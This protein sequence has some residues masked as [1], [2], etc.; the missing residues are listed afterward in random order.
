MRVPG[1]WHTKAEPRLCRIIELNE[2]IEISLEQAEAA[3]E[4]KEPPKS[5]AGDSSGTDKKFK[6][7]VP[8]NTEYGIA[9]LESEISELSQATEGSR[10]RCLNKA[11][12]CLGQLVAGGELAEGNVSSSLVATAILIG[13]LEAEA[14]ST[15][16]SGIQAGMVQPRSAPQDNGTTREQTQKSSDNS[17][18]PKLRTGAEIRNMEIKIEWLIDGIIPKNGVTLLFGRGG[19]GKTTLTL[20]MCQAISSGDNFLGRTTEKT[21]VI[22]IDFENSLSVLSERLRT[23]GADQV[24]FWSSSDSPRRLDQDLSI[25]FNLL[26]KYPG[27]VF[28]FDTLRSAQDGDEND[29][30]F[31][32]S[33]M[34]PLR[35]LRDLG[36]TVI[37]LHHTKKSSDDVYKGS[38][39]IFDLVDHVVGLYP[40]KKAGENK[41]SEGELA[42]IPIYF[43]GTKNKTRYRTFEQYLCFDKELCLFVRV[44]DLKEMML[45]K[46]R[47]KIPEIG[48]IQ[49]NLLPILKTSLGI[50]E[51]KALGLLKEGINRYWSAEKDSKSNNAVTYK[52]FPGFSAP[53]G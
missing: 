42:E 29:S 43:F 17:E 37:L 22:Y 51:G 34:K 47:E 14:R 8:G 3:P 48:I 4:L 1:S 12:F 45:M 40:V 50:S 36:A 41:E 23:T 16:T 27:A 24:W 31:M 52:P 20:Q 18:L 35:I 13:L 38:T 5:T 33:V 15:I 28:V 7:K 6:H 44:I 19:I 2:G 26:K 21:T 32:A 9:A 49:K 46:I 11:A 53:I 30:R 39:A 25:Y 10:N